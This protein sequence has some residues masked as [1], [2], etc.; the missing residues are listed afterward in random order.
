MNIR[1]GSFTLA[2]VLTVPAAALALSP[3]NGGHHSGGHGHHSGGWGG[4]GGGSGGCNQQPDDAEGCTPGYWKNHAERWDNL[5]QDDFTIS[6]KHQAAFN[7]FFGVTSAQSGMQDSDTLLDAVFLGGGGVNALNRH[8]AAAAASADSPAVNYAFSLDEVI[9]TYQDAVGAI[10]GPLGICTGKKRLE[11]QNEKGCPLGNEDPDITPYCTGD[12][13]NCP[14]GDS[15]SGGCPNATGNGALLGGAGSTSVVLDELV[16]TTTQ[17]P[18]NAFAMTFMGPGADNIPFGNG[19]LCA[20]PGGAKLFRFLPALNSGASGSI[21][22]GPGLVDMSQVN[23]FAGGN[24][25]AGS[26]WYFQTY[27]RDLN[28]SCNTNFNLSNALRVD[29]LP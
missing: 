13:G 3:T 29:F 22:L 23:A 21:Q 10:D 19:R 12:E 28:P 2:L 20:S 15:V 4:W 24:I 27:Y 6:V 17:L 8:A 7:Q 26:T 11:K 1:I 18:Q 5:D 14:C 16:L 25:T 9:E